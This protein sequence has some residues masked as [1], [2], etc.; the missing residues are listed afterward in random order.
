[1]L[2]FDLFVRLLIGES[3]RAGRPQ[4]WCHGEEAPVLVLRLNHRLSFQPITL[5]V[6][7]KFFRQILSLFQNVLGPGQPL[8]GFEFLRG[9]RGYLDG[10]LGYVGLNRLGQILDLLR[11]VFL[12]QTPEGL[13]EL[14][15]VYQE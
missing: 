15:V 14:H 2:E 3:R 5:M 7:R 10:A 1:M 4:R 11:I 6:L 8:D 12:D 9:W 13:Q